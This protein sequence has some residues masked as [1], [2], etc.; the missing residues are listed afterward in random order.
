MLFEQSIDDILGY[1]FSF[2]TLAQEHGSGPFARRSAEECTGSI[3]A[4]VDSGMSTEH[5][6]RD[7]GIGYKLSAA[8]TLTPQGARNC[9]N[10]EALREAI[11]DSCNAEYGMPDT[12]GLQCTRSLAIR[13]MPRCPIPAAVP[14]LN[15]KKGTTTLGFKYKGGI[16]LSVDSRA[17]SGQYIASQ[18]VQKVLVINDR[19]LGTMAGGAADCQYWERI[20]GMQ[21]RLWELR[22]GIKITVAGASKILASITYSQRHKGLSMGTMVAGWDHVIGADLYYVDDQGMRLRH[23]I[24]SVG[25]GSTYAYG[26]LDNGYRWDLTDGEAAELGRKAIF[27][28]TFRDGG[29]GGL[30]SV[31]H[32]H[33]DGWTKISKDDQTLMHAKYMG[34]K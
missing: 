8:Q 14:K 33:K 12:D 24:F 27:H 26:V 31:Y 34:G 13:A 20:L 10:N 9:R 7:A 22:N 30:I 6:G 18:T 4:G 1:D 2:K 5:A 16:I 29:S 28:A 21:C 17:S 23:N 19:L 15:L 3:R 11:A 32:I 25:S